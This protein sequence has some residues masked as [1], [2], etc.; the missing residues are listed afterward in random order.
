MATAEPEQQA[1]AEVSPDVPAEVSLPAEEAPLAE[2]ASPDER[3]FEALTEADERQIMAEI[4]GKALGAMIYSYKQEGKTVTGLSY[5]GVFEAVRQMNT[6]QM[7]R[8]KIA[9]E[10]APVFTEMRVEVNTGKYDDDG[11]PRTQERAAVRC[12]VYAVD[13]VYGTARF[14]TATQLREFKLKKPDKKG[15]PIW[16]TDTFADAKALSKASRNAMEGMLPLELVEEL[17]NLYLGKGSVEYIDATAV[18]V[19]DQPPPLDDP[20]AKELG[21]QIREAYADFKQ[22]DAEG[23]KKLPPAQFNRYFMAA[24]H[25][26]ERLEDF[27][28]HMEQLAKDAKCTDAAKEGA[29]A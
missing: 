13:E 28:A 1:Q 12:V 24:Q 26:H 25:S 3:L 20:R 19:T 27:L 23:L 14:G 9:Q 2:V 17:K 11:Q 29:S 21:D 10:P 5:K 18:E 4:E 16:R 6:R 15:N 8:I 22:A 7:G